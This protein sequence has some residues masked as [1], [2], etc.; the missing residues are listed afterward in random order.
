MD[1]LG[2]FDGVLS[3]FSALRSSQNTQE[4]PELNKQSAHAPEK[5]QLSTTQITNEKLVE[6][7]QAQKELA[8]LR[9]EQKSKRLEKDLDRG[10]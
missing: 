2:L 6:L 3:A 8:E 5:E 1:I 10:R 9:Q 7:E 4:Q